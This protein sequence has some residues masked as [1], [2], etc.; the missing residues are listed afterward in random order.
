MTLGDTKDA[1]MLFIFDLTCSLSASPIVRDLINYIFFTALI[2]NHAVARPMKLQF[3][4]ACDSA[5]E[6]LELSC[7]LCVVTGGVS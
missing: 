3:I 2:L 1:C 6:N 4:T 5:I 7:Q